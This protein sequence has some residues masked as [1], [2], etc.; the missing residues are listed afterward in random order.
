MPC[1]LLLAGVVLGATYL[2]WRGIEST[3]QAEE[4][5]REFLRL[6]RE[7][8]G[9]RAYFLTSTRCRDALSLEDHREFADRWLRD[10]GEFEQVSAAEKGMHYTSAGRT[11]TLIYTVEGTLRS[12]QAILHLIHERGEWRI[13]GYQ[14]GVRP[15]SG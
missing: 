12:G 10:L 3:R 9:E 8:Q 6:V 2:V 14:L 11:V 15:S 5:A 4:V 1:L 7:H 13:E